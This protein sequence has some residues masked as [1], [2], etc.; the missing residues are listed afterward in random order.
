[1]AI[2]VGISQYQQPNLNLAYADRDADVLYEFLRT[3]SGG[4]FEADH[5]LKLTNQ[6][7]TTANVTQ[8]LRTFLK[9]PARED[10]VLLYFSCHGSPDPERPENV[11]L[12]TYDTKPNDISGTALPMREIDLC[13]K[14]TLQVERVIILADTCHSGAIA[15]RIGRK[16]IKQAE[17]INR[18]LQEVS[19]SRAGIALLTSAEANEISWEDQKWGGGHGVFTYYLLE[20]MKGAA[21]GSDG[22]VRVGQLF[23][24]VR[25]Q[26]KQA[27]NHS[28]HP[29][30]G[31]NPFD[32]NL[33]IAITTELENEISSNDNPTSLSDLKTL[34][35]LN[36]YT[37]P[38]ASNFKQETSISSE[39]P[40][41]P[42]ITQRR[43]LEQQLKEQQQE[44]DYLTE[45]I[46]FLNQSEKTED[47]TPKQHFRLQQQISEAEQKRD[48]IAQSVDQLE[49]R[50]S[51]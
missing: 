31:T 33:P 13:L 5:I 12:I 19:S 34:N 29:A 2:L 36:F 26:V 28:Q 4:N 27:T 30:I 6:Q 42:S 35:P 51:L 49:K 20:G 15:G 37:L 18:Y 32:R 46:K 14:E 24:Y 8:A 39:H 50:L 43:H 23:E 38:T 40:S 41:S 3:P 7:A 11:Y 47:L 25:E 44:Y 21:S 1:W 16:A 45:Q 22:F 9:K 17:I 10:I 48:E